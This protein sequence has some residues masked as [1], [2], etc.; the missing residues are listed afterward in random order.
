MEKL[1]LEIIG[2]MQMHEK[3]YNEHFNNG[4]HLA[5]DK[6]RIY[7]QGKAA[8]HKEAFNDLR[9]LRDM[10]NLEKAG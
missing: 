5:N 9:R 4:L 6:L 8:G 1:K 3:A 10:I 2:L 7:N